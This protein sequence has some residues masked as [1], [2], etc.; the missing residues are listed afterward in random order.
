MNKPRKLGQFYMVFKPN[1]ALSLNSFLKRMQTLTSQ[2]RKQKSRTKKNK[3][4]MPND[5]EIIE[6]KIRLKKGVPLDVETQKSFR[7]LSKKFKVKLKFL[8]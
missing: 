6:Q 2:V 5:P 7:E 4:M 8:N 3:V 1:A